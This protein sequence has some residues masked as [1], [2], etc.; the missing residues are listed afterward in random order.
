MKRR[1]KLSFP[2]LSSISWLTSSL[3]AR[4]FDKSRQGRGDFDEERGTERNGG[5][6]TN[7]ME[8]GDDEEVDNYTSTLIGVRRERERERKEARRDGFSVR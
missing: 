7:E 5:R 4:Y 2:L 6:S 8:S 1:R 3:N